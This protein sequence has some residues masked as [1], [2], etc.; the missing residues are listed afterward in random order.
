MGDETPSETKRSDFIGGLTLGLMISL[1][2]AVVIS[3]INPEAPSN[4]P[5]IISCHP[6]VAKNIEGE[7]HCAVDDGWLTYIEGET[8]IVHGDAP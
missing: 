7:C 4:D 3:L 1:T 6:H 2:A 5:C 8:W